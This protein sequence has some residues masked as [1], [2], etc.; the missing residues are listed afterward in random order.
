MELT[1]GDVFEGIVEDKN[2]SAVII[3]SQG[4][5]YTFKS[6][7]IYTCT[8]VEP[9]KGKPASPAGQTEPDTLSWEELLRDPYAVGKIEITISNG[10]TF[11]GAVSSI[12]SLTVKIDV[13]GSVIPIEKKIIAQIVTIVPESKK[14]Q[15]KEV[16]A[17][18][19]KPATPLDTV[20]VL[21]KQ[22]TDYGG[23][24]LIPVMIIGT[25][26]NYDITGVTIQTP[27]GIVREFKQDRLYQVNAHSTNTYELKI[28]SYARP[29][30]CSENQIFVDMPPSGMDK[31]F[32]KVC[33]DKY[34]FP[35][36]RDATPQTTISFENAQQACQKLG[37]RLCTVEEWQWACSGIEAYPYPYGPVFDKTIC[38]RDGMTRVEPSGNRN[39]CVGKFGVFDMVGNVFEWVV[40][41]NGKPQLMGGPLSKCQT[42]SPGENTSGKPQVGFRC[43]KSN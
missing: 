35:N 17:A 25:I 7:L 9:P 39:K 11:K 30:F 16:P 14:P 40:D 36:K 19:R 20:Y 32:L 3:E 41:Q 43:C 4:T 23:D 18:V 15:A 26:Q 34:E 22:K 27:N 21:E 6:G 38:N 12:D 10:S 31:P 13:G 42:V 2:D 29:L 24:T 28:K 5:P 8:L 37:K 33:I 1:T